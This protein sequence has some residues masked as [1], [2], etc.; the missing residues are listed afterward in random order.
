M[1]RLQELIVNF[2]FLRQV[3]NESS[4][5]SSEWIDMFDSAVGKY[6]A[7]KQDYDAMRKLYADTA[8]RLS[9]STSKVIFKLL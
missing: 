1:T 7:A 8:S 2:L 6:E 9:A 4:F 5:G 3:M